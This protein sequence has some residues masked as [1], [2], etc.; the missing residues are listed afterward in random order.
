MN[1]VHAA[2]YYRLAR[3]IEEYADAGHAEGHD[4]GCTPG[5]RYLL[6]EENTHGGWWLSTFDTPED[7]ADAH[8]NQEYASEWTRTELLVDL[9]TGANYWPGPATF[10]W[11]PAT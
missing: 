3:E 2:R 6:L 4:E 11:R 8:A 7:A 5:E 10:T 9:D 1:A